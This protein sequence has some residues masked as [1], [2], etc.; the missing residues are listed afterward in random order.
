MTEQRFV[1]DRVAPLYDRYR[2]G[3]P[4]E[5]VDRVLAY[6]QLPPGGRILEV[7]C[8][9]G[10]AS[11]AFASRGHRL[12][13]LEP[14]PHMAALA[15]ANLGRFPRLEIVLETF[16]NWPLQEQPFQLV[17]SAQAFHWVDPDLRFSKAARALGSG[18]VLALFAHSLLPDDDSV[19]EQ[20]DRAYADCAPEMVARLPG[21]TPAQGRLLADDFSEA[22][23]FGQVVYESHPWSRELSTAAY[24]GM[25]Q[26]QSDHCM[27]PEAQLEALLERVGRVIDESGGSRVV[28]YVTSLLMAQRT[29]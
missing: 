2:P 11:A 26:T 14:S 27:L 17:I 9:T 7:G 24:V 10:Q 12:I 15:H 25:L 6:T 29:P 19:R 4:E 21:S 3:Y 5:L 13:C 28:R 22:E 20:L 23:N 1:F 18:G 8:G 16:E